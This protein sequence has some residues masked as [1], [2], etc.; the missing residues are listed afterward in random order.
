[1]GEIGLNDARG[2]FKELAAPAFLEFW[3]EYQRDAVVDD[4]RFGLIYRR[5]LT[6]VFFMNHMADKIAK[7]RG[8]KDPVDVIEAIKGVDC[9]AGAALEI[10]RM[11]TNDVKHSKNR[12]HSYD[13]RDR[14][15]PYDKPGAAQLPSW[16]YTDS[17]G[18]LHELGDVAW[19]T[20]CYWIDRRHERK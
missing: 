6:A 11:L 17:L 12:R 3:D 8:I 2:Y 14:N 10:C 4:E 16:T 9:E 13:F 7:Q 20:W 19:R 1:M 18:G 5:L 15:M